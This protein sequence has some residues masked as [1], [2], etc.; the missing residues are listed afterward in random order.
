MKKSSDQINE[1]FLILSKSSIFNI[2]LLQTALEK[3]SNRFFLSDYKTIEKSGEYK[4]CFNVK[5]GEKS[6]YAK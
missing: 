1:Y 4:I 2:I 3:Y 6:H 5:V